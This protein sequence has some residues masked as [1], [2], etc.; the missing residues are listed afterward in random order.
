MSDEAE[1]AL[2]RQKIIE[3]E[4]D[5]EFEEETG[6]HDEGKSGSSGERRKCPFL[7]TINRHVLDFDMEKVCSVTL[8]NLNVYCCLVCGKFFQGRGKSTPA[9]THSVQCGHFVFVNLHDARSFCLPDN[10]EVIDTSLD[11]VKRCLA[12]KY[13]LSEISLLDENDSLARDVNGVAYLPGFVGMNNLNSSSHINVILHALSHVQPLRDFFLQPES[14]SYSKSTLVSRLGECIRKLWSAHNFKSVVSPQ[15]LAHEITL[16]SQKIVSGQSGECVDLLNWLL[17]ELNRGLTGSVKKGPPTIINKCFQGTVEIKE[18]NLLEGGNWDTKIRHVPFNYLRLDIPPPPLFRDAEG[19][20]IIP[21]IPIFDLLKKFD[22]STWSEQV[23]VGSHI[24]R[25]YQILSLPNYL[26]F[27][28]AR[29]NKNNFFLEH[30][31]TIV[32]FPGNCIKSRT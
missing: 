9:Y 2:K 4:L 11:D 30:N 25:Q 16:S 15:E 26:I 14:Y 28:L 12:P 24:R 29:F 20:L 21:R 17:G 27:H 32:T 6:E 13:N 1:R 22:G 23:S 19:G 7:D 3:S 31:P 5:F 10:Y 8:T 18:M